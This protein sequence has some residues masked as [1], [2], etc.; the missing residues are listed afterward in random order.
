M[1]SFSGGVGTQF[2][3]LCCA[4]Q[5]CRPSSCKQNRPTTHGNAIANGRIRRQGQL[6]QQSRRSR[7]LYREQCTSAL[8]SGRALEQ[9]AQWR[10][11]GSGSQVWAASTMLARPERSRASAPFCLCLVILA[12]RFRH[13]ARHR[14]SKKTSNTADVIRQPARSWDGASKAFS[15]A[16]RSARIY[17]QTR[18]KCGRVSRCTG[19]MC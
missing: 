16:T 11:A 8:R 3:F 12:P 9:A 17:H 13:G 1:G 19:Q 2:S 4:E 7:A 15:S 10:L 5:P 6:S 14:T 18:S